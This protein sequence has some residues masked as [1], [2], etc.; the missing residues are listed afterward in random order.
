MSGMAKVKSSKTQKPATPRSE[1]RRRAL[2]LAAREVFLEKGYAGTSVE[3]VMARVGGSKATLYSYFG[4]KDGLF[5]DII[6]MQ[7]EEFLANLAIPRELGDDIEKTLFEFGRRAYALFTDAKRIAMLRNMISEAERFP[8]LAERVYANGPRRGR[9]L[10]AE[11]L[12]RA[13]DAGQI[14][15]PRPDFAAIQFM[16]MIKAHSQWRALFGMAPFDE[17]INADEFVR[18][19]VRTFLYGR[20]R[21]DQRKP[22]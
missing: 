4:N 7:C 9:A 17:K 1:E 6:L 18:D 5:G 19:A 11:L 22:A 20:A 2:L 12:Q 3:D 21:P 15:C 14:D 8:Q 13:H 10:L 16:E